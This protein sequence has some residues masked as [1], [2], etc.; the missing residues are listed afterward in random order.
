LKNTY[1]ELM[2]SSLPTRNTDKVVPI[3]E[4]HGREEKRPTF[5]YSSIDEAFPPVDPGL[6][7]FGSSVLVQLRNPKTRTA[8]GIH[9]TRDTTD[10][11]MWNSS[12]ARVI[13][14]GPAC[15]RNRDTLEV[16]PEGEWCKAGQFVRVPKYGGDRWEVPWEHTE[17]QEISVERETPSR[18]GKSSRVVMETQTR[19]IKLTDKVV[20]ILFRDLDLGGEITCDPLSVIA[21]I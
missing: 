4:G 11:D 10:T 20:F 18:D 6:R 2:S 1:E 3:T 14:L 21:F 7:P 19:L 16:W 12:V 15:F 9:L 13:A 17:E 8:G 5:A